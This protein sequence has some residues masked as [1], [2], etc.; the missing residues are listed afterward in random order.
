MLC[1]GLANGYNDGFS[2]VVADNREA[3]AGYLTCIGHGSLGELTV[4]NSA[5][6]TSDGSGS[7]IVDGVTG[8]INH[9]GGGVVKCI[10]GNG[11]GGSYGEGN[12]SSGYSSVGGG[13]N[14]STGL[15]NPSNCLAVFLDYVVECVNSGSILQVVV[16]LGSR[17]AEVG[18]GVAAVVTGRI[19]VVQSNVGSKAGDVGLVVPVALEENLSDLGC[20]SFL[21]LDGV[22]V[23]GGVSAGI[24][25]VVNLGAEVKT[26]EVENAALLEACSGC[27]VCNNIRPFNR[28]YAT[29][30]AV[31]VVS[32]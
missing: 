3:A 10:V 15:L 25:V 24:V 30:V 6:S 9:D 13:V 29:L 5:L 18:D 19:I 27:I 31:E 16:D 14:L 32:A 20:N 28:S 4:G 26:S 1:W 11:S 8:H 2:T 21:V 17:A 12:A 23:L 7:V 22:Q